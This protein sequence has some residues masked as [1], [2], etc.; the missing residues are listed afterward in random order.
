MVITLDETKEN[1]AKIKV[2]GVGG[3]GG[4]A[5]NRMIES[6]LHGVEFIA[7]N[8]DAM[9]L[10]NN[11]AEKKISIGQKLCKGLGAGSRPDK[12]YEAIQ[13]DRR[14]VEEALS[15]A[16]MVFIAGG[17]GG[18]TGTGAAPVVAEISRELGILTVGVVTEPF[19]WEG[20]VRKRHS[21]KGLDNL[22]ANVDT[23]IA[24]QNQK[25]F[26]VIPKNTTVLDAYKTVD[27]VLMDAVK[28]ISD[29]ILNH[30]FMQVDFADV[31][32]IMNNGGE[33]LI[34]TG[35][36]EGE[37]KAQLAAELAIHSP[38]LENISISGAG[39]I[40]VN[41]T[42]GD[43]LAMHEINDVMSYIYES[44]GDDN[45]PHIIFGNVIDSSMG[46]RVA[47][48]V[49]ATGFSNG[50]VTENP[51]VVQE[52]IAPQVTPEPELQ[53]IEPV[54]EEIMISQ[55]IE[56]VISKE[57][58]DALQE[59]HTAEAPIVP[60][61]ATE[62]PIDVSIPKMNAEFEDSFFG[63]VSDDERPS[64]LRMNEESSSFDVRSQEVEE[65]IVTE[66]QDMSDYCSE[67]QKD[68]EQISH[69]VRPT[70]R[71]QELNRGMVD[72][73]VDYSKPAFQRIG[74]LQGV[75]SQMKES[76]DLYSQ[77]NSKV[78][79]RPAFLRFQD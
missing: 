60:E 11:L 39:G 75:D 12:G 3:A 21:K 42:G 41:I 35:I 10:E 71:I 31:R 5:L 29:I 69:V 6:G 57:E 25:I 52:V 44:V 4:N 58:V 54:Q 13:E 45:E 72:D 28:G 65:T 36:A 18:G 50:K 23:I 26:D 51:P 2:V 14:L 37:G 9:A 27:G 76:E 61:L 1:R 7:I 33:A 59:V 68:S 19:N 24:I 32:E 70:Q 20:P 47:V 67:L 30:G 64:F 38:L 15:G 78:D 49:I 46:E 79:E 43:E 34:G 17:M 22:T 63:K 56:P 8:T 16:D 53:V 73:G 74:G 48:T 66:S 55:N 77:E 40:L 62:E